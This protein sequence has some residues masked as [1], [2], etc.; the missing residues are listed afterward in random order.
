MPRF[1][2]YSKALV[3][4]PETSSDCADRCF[5]DRMPETFFSEFEATLEVHVLKRWKH[6]SLLHYMIGGEPILAR[7]FARWLVCAKEN[8]GM[9]NQHVFIDEDIE[10]DKFHVTNSGAVEINVRECMKYLTTGEDG[11]PVDPTSILEDEFVKRHWD[12]IEA[13]ALVEDSS[14]AIRLFDKKED[15]EFLKMKMT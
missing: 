15:G 8:G 9:A 14:P 4:V 12:L 11:N 7:E 13:L 2:E 1:A 3:G 5:F 6:P 10:L